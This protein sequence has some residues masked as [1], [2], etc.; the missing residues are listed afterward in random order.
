MKKFRPR[1]LEKIPNSILRAKEQEQ[2]RLEA[3]HRITEEQSQQESS[4]KRQSESHPEAIIDDVE[5]KAH[6][7]IGMTKERDM[8]DY[9]QLVG[10]EDGIDIEKEPV[11]ESELGGRSGEGDS[12]K[13]SRYFDEDEG[14][15][16]EEMY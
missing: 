11:G 1:R 6:A 2:A 15:G 8:D 16:E 4:N 5:N 12:A 10:N 7:L 13:N 9:E 3:S 14:E